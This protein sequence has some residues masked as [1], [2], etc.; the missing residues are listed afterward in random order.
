[1]SLPLAHRT[2][3]ILAEGDLCG[4][5]V[6]D[7]PLGA[8]TFGEVFEAHHR[9]TDERFAIKVMRHSYANN[10]DAMRRHLAEARLLKHGQHKNIVKVSDYGRTD[11]R[12]WFAMELLKGKTL[13]HLIYGVPIAL[14]SA[15]YIAREIADGLEAIHEC[16]VIHRD[17]KPENIFVTEDHQVKILDLGAARLYCSVSRDSNPHVILGTLEYLAPERIG[18]GVVDDASDQYA[19]GLTLWEMLV[20]QH[21]FVFH[22]D[23]AQVERGNLKVMGNWHM[24]WDPPP[25]TQFGF[26]EDVSALVSRMIRKNPHERFRSMAKVQLKIDEVIRKYS[27]KRALFPEELRI[28]EA[29]KMVLSTSNHVAFSSGGKPFGPVS[30]D[31]IFKPYSTA[32]VEIRAPQTPEP[33]NVIRLPGPSVAPDASTDF[34]SFTTPSTQ[35]TL[36]TQSPVR[37]QAAV[38]MALNG[39]H[40]IARGPITGR[41]TI[42]PQLTDIRYLDALLAD[43]AKADTRRERRRG[44]HLRAFSFALI[45]WCAAGICLGCRLV[46]PTNFLGIR[47]FHTLCELFFIYFIA[48]A[49]W[50]SYLAA[51]R[52]RRLNNV[53]DS[54]SSLDPYETGVTP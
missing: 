29:D 32:D 36:E 43:V 42:P 33:T 9:W 4:S 53:E 15:L 31:H 21:P 8:G 50:M 14:T 47:R 5:Y 25:L 54:S 6:I 24:T 49:G 13:R 27:G 19:L 51:K 1:M 23:I 37:Y 44:R 28:L 3:S 20:G 16:N 46:G 11:D 38:V 2:E 35:T 12:I 34:A 30:L 39:T 7:K 45:F 52:S 10:K 26:P 18:G 22:P 17:I 48:L 40:H 41:M